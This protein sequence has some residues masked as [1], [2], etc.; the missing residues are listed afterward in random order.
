MKIEVHFF[1][2]TFHHAIV[3]VPDDLEKEPKKFPYTVQPQTPYARQYIS[4]ILAESLRL[5]TGKKWHTEKGY[6]DM[7]GTWQP[8]DNYGDNVIK[9]IKAK[10]VV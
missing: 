5:R 3:D 10:I 4:D 2:E 7:K 8:Q 1:A 6:V 9:I